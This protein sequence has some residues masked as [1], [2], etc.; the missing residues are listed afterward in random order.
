ME[1]TIREHP[2]YH[3]KTSII[4]L[5]FEYSF[6]HTLKSIQIFKSNKK[7]HLTVVQEVLV[8][9]RTECLL[10]SIVC[11]HCPDTMNSLHGLLNCERGGL[12]CH[13]IT[14]AYRTR[15]NYIA[16]VSPSV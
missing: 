10:T 1:L 11:K 14:P 4:Q 5:R 9:L 3:L 12:D 15:V 2:S 16:H 8:F 6:E 13:V 7:W